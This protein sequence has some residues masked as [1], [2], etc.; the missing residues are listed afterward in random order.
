MGMSRYKYKLNKIQP[1][2]INR[3]KMFV[4]VLES[5]G[6]W[7][8][9]WQSGSKKG[10]FSGFR[11]GKGA[12]KGFW[13]IWTDL[14]RN[15]TDSHLSWRQVEEHEFNWSIKSQ[16]A[17]DQYFHPGKIKKSLGNFLK[18]FICNACFLFV[19]GSSWPEFVQIKLGIVH[20]VI[21]KYLVS[22]HN[23]PC[24]WS[25]PSPRLVCQRSALRPITSTGNHSH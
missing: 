13:G 3:E 20:L 18:E 1:C 7:G 5:W 4:C 19:G 15:R 11:R 17:I 14:P 25:Y 12:A 10:P 2:K 21:S 9:F 22:V 8:T 24:T 16:I 23:T 6:S